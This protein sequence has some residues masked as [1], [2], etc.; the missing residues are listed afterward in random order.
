MITFIENSYSAGA[1]AIYSTITD[2]EQ[3]AAKCNELG[4]YLATTTSRYAEDIATMPY[5]LG[6]TGVDLKKS[7]F[8]I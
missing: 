8:R 5:N 2:T 7:Q 6:I 3:I 4:L 1:D